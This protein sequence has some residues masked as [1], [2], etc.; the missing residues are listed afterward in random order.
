MIAIEEENADDNE[1]RG[2]K[3]KANCQ[4]EN[5]NGKILKITEIK[6]RYKCWRLFG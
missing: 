3:G 1:V 4:F 6:S 2:K 5:L